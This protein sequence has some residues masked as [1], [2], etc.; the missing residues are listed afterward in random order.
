MVGIEGH[1]PSAPAHIPFHTLNIDPPLMGNL[2]FALHYQRIEYRTDNRS[3]PPRL[4]EHTQFTAITLDKRPA[5]V[6]Y[7]EV[8]VAGFPRPRVTNSKCI[9]SV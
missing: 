9:Q 7:Q 6:E 1:L 4:Q 8:A 5:Q 2:L 3:Y